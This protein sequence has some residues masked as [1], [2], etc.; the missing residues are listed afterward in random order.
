VNRVHNMRHFA[1]L[2]R[3]TNLEHFGPYRSME[4]GKAF[5][6]RVP[7]MRYGRQWC[8]VFHIID[9]SSIQLR[10]LFSPC[11]LC[12]LRTSLLCKI[13]EKLTTFNLLFIWSSYLMKS[14]DCNLRN[15]IKCVSTIYVERSDIKV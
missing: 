10:L 11:K 14:L 12:F 15:C 1:P 9:K 2:D 4:K 6:N 5:E 13:I 3:P 8:N 7:L